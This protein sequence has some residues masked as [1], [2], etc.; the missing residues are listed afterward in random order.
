MTSANPLDGSS[1]RRRIPAWFP[2]RRGPA[3]RSRPQQGHGVHRGRARRRS[4]CAACCRRASSPRTSR[5]SACWRTSARKPDRP[6][7]VHLPHRAAGP[8]RDA[9]LPRRCI[10]HIDEMMPIIYTPTVGQACQEFGHIFRRPRG[11]YICAEDRGRIRA[12]PA[13]LA[14]TTT[15]ASS[16]SPTAS[17]SSASATSAP[18]AWAS[19]SASSRS[20]P[21]APASTPDQCLPVTLDVGTNNAELLDDPLYIGLR[22][23][24]PARRGVR[25][26]ASRNS[27]TPSHEVFPDALL[28]F[29][30]F[31]NRQRLPPARAAT[32]TGSAPSTTTSRAP[33]PWR[34]PASTP[35]L[36][37]TG[38][39]LCAT[40]ACCSS[41][42]ARPPSASPTSSSRR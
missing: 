16:S 10:D 29:E 21:P 3:A 7:A 17:A 26:A 41:A 30:D 4:A 36:R 18:T 6:R 22:A 13:Q 27:S 1:P 14:A 34:S 9:V 19:R 23:A 37:I 8:Q 28:Q 33:P 15:W 39:K 31:A 42:P 25:R 2:A 5:W 12:D 35:P 32:A 40:S 11:L 24:A 20:T 38:G